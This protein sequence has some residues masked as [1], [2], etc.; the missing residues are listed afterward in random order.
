MHFVQ[1]TT[2]YV[3]VS[4]CRKYH[5]VAQTTFPPNSKLLPPLLKGIPSLFPN[6]PSNLI[7]NITRIL[8]VNTTKD[9]AISIV[10]HSFLDARSPPR[11]DLLNA[12]HITAQ[13]YVDLI[14]AVPQADDSAS[15]SA[16]RGVRA[17]VVLMVGRRVEER[18]P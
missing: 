3:A 12:R 13:L 8:E 6:P 4:S 7:A 2:S 18:R 5:R 16:K 1:Q 10:L 17:Q 11:D 15:S 9:P 14:A